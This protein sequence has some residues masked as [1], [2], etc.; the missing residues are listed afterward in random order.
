ML[1]TDRFLMQNTQQ[2][3]FLQPDSPVYV[4]C[5]RQCED[6]RS[7]AKLLQLRMVNC[8]EDTVE[9]VVFDVEGL[10]AWNEVSFSLPALVMTGCRA[11]CGKIF[12]ED[13]VFS[14]KGHR[15]ARLRITVRQV[16]FSNGMVWK[17]QPSHSITTVQEAGWEVCNCGLPYPKERVRCMLCGAVLKA[18]PAEEAGTVQGA[19]QAAMDPN[20]NGYIP[21]PVPEPKTEPESKPEPIVRSRPPMP[22]V[23]PEETFPEFDEDDEEEDEDEGVPIWLSVLL[24]VFGTLALL[25]LL[26]FGAFFLHQYIL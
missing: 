19:P 21:T 1:Q 23:R 12:G 9:T 14:L 13:K 18:E 6:R 25:A 2:H 15:A 8:A 4:H 11:E 22:A 3:G 5:T 7:G 16:I 26:A 17:L 20:E 10:T 24:C